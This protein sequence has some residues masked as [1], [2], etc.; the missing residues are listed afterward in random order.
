MMS[1]SGWGHV[2]QKEL[3]MF[4]TIP[5]FHRVQMLGVGECSCYSDMLGGRV[6]ELESKSRLSSNREV[7]QKM[8][9][10]A[11]HELNVKSV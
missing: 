8:I 3:A 4:R 9:L 6:S 2:I 10:K 1:S 7:G 11:K 5:D